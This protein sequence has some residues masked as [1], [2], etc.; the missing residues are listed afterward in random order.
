MSLYDI[1]DKTG[2]DEFGVNHNDFSLRDEIEYN[3]KRAK[4]KELEQCLKPN[5]YQDDY[6]GR[7]KAKQLIE[8][9]RCMEPTRP[10]SL[11]FDGGNLIWLEN[12][13]P[14]KYYPAQ[15][16]HNAFQSSQYTNVSDDGPIPE[17]YYMLNKNS[18]QDY[19]ENLWYKLKRHQPIASITT[20]DWK[21]TPAAWGHQRIPIQPREGT[22]TFGRHSMYIHGGDNGFGSAG[23]ID[24]ERGMPEF[25]KD[26]QNYN[27]DL[28]L[29]VKYPKDW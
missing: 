8:S 2:F 12:G 13:K 6:L 10:G 25:Y 29:E 16:G 4:E 7:L 27:N 1:N 24:L 15:S 21:S 26:W 11:Q 14:V 18:G 5:S 9:R 20:N 17:G 28:S 3:F 19:K 23:C 22:N